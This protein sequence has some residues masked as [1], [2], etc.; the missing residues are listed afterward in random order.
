[1]AAGEVVR[2]MMREPASGVSGADPCGVSWLRQRVL[3][4]AG[5][6]DLSVMTLV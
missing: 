3:P 2:V 6:M 1:M 4:G 5:G